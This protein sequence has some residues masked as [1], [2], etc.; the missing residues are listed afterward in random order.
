M[1]VLNQAS[2]GQFNVLISLVRALI[3]FGPRSRQD[4]LKLCGAGF[5]GVQDGKL[6]Q[7][8]NRWVELGLL[9]DGD[10]VSIGEP[11][12]SQLGKDADLAELRLPGCVREI[13]LAEA[14]NQRFWEN[15]GSKSADLTRALAWLL[16]QDIFELDASSADTVMKLESVQFKDTGRRIIQNDT[17]WNG[18][19]TWMSYLGFARHGSPISIDPTVAVKEVLTRVFIDDAVMTASAFVEALAV[20]LPVLDNGAYRLKVEEAM[21]ERA[22]PRPKAGWLSTALSRSIQRIEF[23]RLIELDQRSDASEGA[24]LTGRG[25]RAWRQFTH[26]RFLGPARDHA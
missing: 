20:T 11:Y 3:R 22:W 24:T 8:L 10:H 5:P 13:A 6:A 16:A 9:T 18:L 1:S 12:R 19:R 17:R 14:N 7:T 25:Q 4:L 21:D 15:E 26:V 2:D 23:E